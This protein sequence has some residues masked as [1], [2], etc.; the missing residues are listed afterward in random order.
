MQ[1]R[2]LLQNENI[3]SGDLNCLFNLRMEQCTFLEPCSLIWVWKWLRSRST[4]RWN[5]SDPTNT[6]DPPGLVLTEDESPASRS[7]W[8]ISDQTEQ[9]L[10]RENGV[11]VSFFFKWNKT[12][13]NLELCS[14]FIFRRLK[15]KSFK[16][17]NHKWLQWLYLS[18]GHTD[19]R[20]KPSFSHTLTMVL[21]PY[22]PQM[23]LLRLW[24]KGELNI[25]LKTCS[26]SPSNR[27]DPTSQ[28]EWSTLSPASDL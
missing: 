13:L 10:H 2:L 23:E 18:L 5:T 20:Q 12:Y 27:A 21:L 4:R 25:F 14:Y 28:M 22:L 24:L 3:L 8:S 9:F 26:N 17:L 6:V 1:W 16:L 7:F 19:P 11:I 15:V